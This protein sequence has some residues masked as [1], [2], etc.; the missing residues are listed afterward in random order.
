LQPGVAEVDPAGGRLED[1]G[2]GAAAREAAHPGE[3]ERD[4]SLLSAVPVSAWSNA[5]AIAAR[6]QL[7]SM[8]FTTEAWS[9]SLWST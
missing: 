2:R 7:Y 4:A 6:F 9:L 8:K 5:P 3:V 1:L